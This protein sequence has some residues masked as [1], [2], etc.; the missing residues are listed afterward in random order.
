[1]NSETGDMLAIAIEAL[2]EHETDDPALA[3]RI[4]R[5]RGELADLQTLLD[6]RVN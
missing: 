4:D 3:E 5:V 1:M 2:E 6:G